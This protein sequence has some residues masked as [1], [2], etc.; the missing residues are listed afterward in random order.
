MESQW[1]LAR[2]GT[3]APERWDLLDDK[4]KSEFEKMNQDQMAKAVMRANEDKKIGFTRSQTIR[5]P[6]MMLMSSSGI[7]GI[8]KAK[9]TDG[10]M[11]DDSHEIFLDCW[12]EEKSAETISPADNLL[13]PVKEG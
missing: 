10:P 6:R 11:L 8:A 4:I 5:D 13:F 7:V 1:R 9:D 12:G 3:I 2:K